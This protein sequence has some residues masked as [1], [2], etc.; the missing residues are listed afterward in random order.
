MDIP[1]LTDKELMYSAT[2]RCRCGAGL[3]HPLDHDL[4]MKIRAWVC[5]RVLRGEGQAVDQTISALGG[6]P[7]PGDHDSFDFAFYKIREE[8]SVNNTGGRSTRPPGT[9]ART[10]GKVHS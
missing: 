4:A 8:T 2:A 6:D 1:K 3:A 9:I 5:A 10:I 7:P